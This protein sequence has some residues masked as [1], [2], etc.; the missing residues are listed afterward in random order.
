[1]AQTRLRE[2]TQVD[3][4]YDLQIDFK[5]ETKTVR[6]RHNAEGDWV[7]ELPRSVDAVVRKMLV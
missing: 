5:D 6:L 3:N 1:M 4:G 2:I 7:I